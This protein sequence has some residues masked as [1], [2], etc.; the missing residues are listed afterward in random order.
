MRYRDHLMEDR[1]TRA[2]SRAR[3]RIDTRTLSISHRQEV[4]EKDGSHRVGH[5]V[6]QQDDRVLV[7]VYQTNGPAKGIKLLNRRTV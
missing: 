7:C 6:Q 1:R 3:P 2:D 4:L 5:R